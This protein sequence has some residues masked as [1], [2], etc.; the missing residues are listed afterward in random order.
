MPNETAKDLSKDNSTK[1][2]DKTSWL[3][4]SKD[5]A[6]MR[7]QTNPSNSK[8]SPGYSPK[9][10]QLELDNGYAQQIPMIKIT[11]NR[12]STMPIHAPNLNKDFGIER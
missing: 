11:Q 1:N 12:K 4:P 10:R 2:H 9:S 7:F 8:M 5:N 3:L 6:S